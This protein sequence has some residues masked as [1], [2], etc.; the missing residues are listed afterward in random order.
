MTQKA[1]QIQPIPYQGSKRKIATQIMQYAPRKFKRLVEPFAGSAAI[2]LFTAYHKYTDSFL[3]NDVYEPLMELWRLIIDDPE[4]CAREYE[5]IWLGQ[6]ENS[7]KHF[8]KVREEFNSDHDPI[9]LLYL[10]ARCVKNSIRFNSKGEFNQSEDKRRKGRSP[11]NMRKQLLM[12][13]LLLK[14][15]TEIKS[16]DYLSVLESTTENDLVY[17]DPPYQG[18]SNGK[19]PR[20]IKG[21][22]YEK[23]VSSLELLLEK[24]VP[25]LLSLD[26][27]CGNKTYGKT[28]PEYLNLQKIDVYA[29]RSS[30]ATLNGK[31]HE[32]VES[33]YVSPNL[34]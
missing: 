2:T 19:D 30:Q 8:L 32:T 1:I 24:N 11:E 31:E 10:S 18:T 14:G 28:L 27:K 12:T 5:K 20:Y 26:G 33:L 7:K 6:K 23:L 9:K 29:G 4:F 25:F 16:D 17:M 13:S 22:D 15:R 34:F 21:L 3:I